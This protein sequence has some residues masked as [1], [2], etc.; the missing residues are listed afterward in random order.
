ML[1]VLEAATGSGLRR[2][3]L[4][5]RGGRYS[6][7]SGA[8]LFA[9]SFAYVR[10]VGVR[11]VGFRPAL[12]P[13]REAARSRLCGRRGKREPLP[14]RCRGKHQQSSARPVA[15]AN[16]VQGDEKW[17]SPDRLKS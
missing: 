16:A 2:Q 10:S 5:L 11:H 7:S 12:A 9:L 4:A 1:A 17:I 13:K 8:G 3:R 14:P 15:P 6:L